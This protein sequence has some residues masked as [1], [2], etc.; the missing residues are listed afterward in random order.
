MTRIHTLSFQSGG[1]EAGRFLMVHVA[2]RN[3]REALRV[4]RLAAREHG[5]SWRL[6]HKTD[7][8]TAQPIPVGEVLGLSGPYDWAMEKE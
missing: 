7:R 2:H 5:P 3:M 4:A 6:V 8:R 1:P